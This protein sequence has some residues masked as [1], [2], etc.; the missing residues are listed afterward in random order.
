MVLFAASRN[1]PTNTPTSPAPKRKFEISEYI[2]PLAR[3]ALVKR[4]VLDIDLK[5]HGGRHPR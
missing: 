2:Q 4:L 5:L 1:G 3:P